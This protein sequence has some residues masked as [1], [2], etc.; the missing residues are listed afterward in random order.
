[1]TPSVRF[2][3]PGLAR[4][5]VACLAAGALPSPAG[6]LT[7]TPSY[8]ASITSDPKASSIEAVIN[9]AITVYATTFSNAVNVLIYFQEGGE[10]GD[11]NTVSYYDPYTS[12]YNGLVAKDANAAAIAGLNANGGDALTNGGVNPVGG[13][14]DIAV[15]SANGRAVGLANAP[16]CV[17]TSTGAGS[18]GG[19]VPNACTLGTSHAV[20]AIISLNVAAT[21]VNSGTYDL[22][23][24]TEHEIDE[25]LGL[26]S[27]V[28]N[29]D[30]TVSGSG[31]TKGSSYATLAYSYATPEDL[32][33]YNASGQRSLG[34]TCSTTPYNTP[35][36]TPAAYFAYG[37]GTGNIAQFNN[38]CNGGDFG[39]WQSSPLPTG[40]NP[41]VQDAFATSGTTPRLGTSEIDAL[42]ALGYTLVPEPAGLAV[43]GLGC[44]VLAG[45]R[46]RRG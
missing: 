31:C 16:D 10:L 24:A 12:F 4:W 11:S 36:T 39:D 9:A 5:L 6:A 40:T 21:T 8:D 38:D 17:V 22:L 20:D 13:K 15:K 33:R 37:S 23:G 29:C 46:R 27:A 19:N 44:A 28:A 30:A 3:L 7:I 2:R 32:F 43:L 42:T 35:A 41:Q 25:V 45:L 18:S 34:T 26:G 14:A 1:M